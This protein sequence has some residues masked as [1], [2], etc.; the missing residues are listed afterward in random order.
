M[1]RLSISLRLLGGW[2]WWLSGSLGLLGGWLWWLPGSLGLLGVR[3][4]RLLWISLLGLWPLVR[5]G[6]PGR[7]PAGL[8]HIV[9]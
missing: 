4:G 7:L 9:R 5:F 8:I 1:A 6:L 2:L 3:L